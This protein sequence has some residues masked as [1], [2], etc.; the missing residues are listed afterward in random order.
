MH[1]I[2][3]SRLISL[4]EENKALKK[5]IIRAK[6]KRIEASRHAENLAEANYFLENCL[7]EVCIEINSLKRQI[8]YLTT[9][10]ESI[11]SVALS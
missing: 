11:S 4:Q 2:V 1:R 10:E 9:Q 7:N 6:N 3:D 8:A 5:L